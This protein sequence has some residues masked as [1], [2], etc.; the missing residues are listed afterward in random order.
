VAFGGEALQI[1]THISLFSKTF[2]YAGR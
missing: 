1:F 2:S